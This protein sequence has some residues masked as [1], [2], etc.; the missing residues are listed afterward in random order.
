MF[1]LT[2]HVFKNFDQFL[3]FKMKT[4]QVEICLFALSID[5]ST[6]ATLIN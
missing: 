2:L 4:L 5:I 1:T 6:G 3:N